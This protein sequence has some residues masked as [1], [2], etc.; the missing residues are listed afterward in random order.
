MPF[1]KCDPE[2]PGTDLV[3]FEKCPLIVLSILSLTVKDAPFGIVYQV[4]PAPPPLSH[5]AFRAPFTLAAAL[6]IGPGYPQPFG[7]LPLGEDGAPIQAVSQL[8]H[9]AFPLRQ[10]PVH[11]RFEL[12]PK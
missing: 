9:H 7:D 8:D 11:D 6:Y 4:F 10:D 2:N 12:G 1:P 5:K 3:V